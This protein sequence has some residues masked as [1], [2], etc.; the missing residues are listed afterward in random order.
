MKSVPS[1]SSTREAGNLVFVSGQIAFNADGVVDGGVAEQTQ[2]CIDG[3]EVALRPLEL[4]L[5]DIV[6]TTVF[7][8][9]PAD[10]AEFDQA[11]RS[12]FPSNPPVRS[13]V[14]ASLVI[15]GA[16]VEIDCV[17]HLRD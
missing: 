5:A 16:R 9:D 8:T 10:F 2:R 3:L 1:F 11:Y 15:P 17:A 14:V 7:L 12:R 13:T 6:K 4:D